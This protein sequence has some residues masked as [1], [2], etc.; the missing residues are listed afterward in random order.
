MTPLAPPEELLSE[1]DMGIWED[2]G[3]TVWLPRKLWPTRVDA[4]RFA[5]LELD[6]HW[7]DTRL[8]LVMM[9]ATDDQAREVFYERCGRDDPGAF[10]CW[11]LDGA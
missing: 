3:T 10:E 9:R 4:K 6:H 7:V 11:E 2:G 1:L 5:L 8:R